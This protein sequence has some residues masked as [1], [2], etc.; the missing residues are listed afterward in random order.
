MI[1]VRLLLRSI[2]TTV[3]SVQKMLQKDNLLAQLSIFMGAITL[4]SEWFFVEFCSGY[5]QYYSGPT[6][7]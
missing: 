6:Y 5:L 1:G 2:V 4:A 3:L 7:H